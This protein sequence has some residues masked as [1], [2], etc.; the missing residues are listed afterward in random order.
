[1]LLR[2]RGLR[3]LLL[4][5]AG[6]A[7]VLAVGLWALHQQ[8]LN[9]E[10]RHLS[11]LAAAVA[12]QADAT[13]DAADAA[14]RAT[15]D[16]LRAGLLQP[17]SPAAETLLQARITALPHFRALVITDAAGRPVATSTRV[18]MANL[19]L[20]GREVA[21]TLGESAGGEPWVGAP[22][23]TPLDGRLAVTLATDW[24]DA[25]GSFRGTVA[26]LADPEFL[27]R[28]FARL[29]VSAD[30]RMAILRRDLALIADGPG[31]P[32][33]DPLPPELVKSLWQQPT[34]HTQRVTLTRGGERLLAARVLDRHRLLLLVTRDANVALAAWTQQAAVV[35]TFAAS[36]LLAT[37]LLGLRHAQEQVLR[38][39]AEE[40]LAQDQARALRAVQAAQEGAWEWQ[41]NSGHGFLSPRMR[42][43]LSIAP[44]ACAEAG[45]LQPTLHPDDFNALHQV[46]A[47]ARDI[48]FEHEFRVRHEQADW[49]HLRVRVRGMATPDGAGWL[50]GGT[51]V[52]I[53]A[54]V[55]ARQERERL[56]AQLALARRLEALGTLAGG[57]AHDFNNILASV[58][59]YSEVALEKVGAQGSAA[60][61]LQQVLQAG[62]RGRS[63][64]ERVLAF[65]RGAA[66]ATGF[67]PLQSLLGEVL[68]RLRARLPPNVTVHDELLAPIAGV[69]ADAAAVYEAVMNVCSNGVQAMHASGG[70]L[71]LRLQERQVETPHTVFEGRLKTGA[72]VQLVVQDEGP[73]IAPQALPRLFEPFYT[74]KAPGEG[75]GLGM[76][77]VHRVMADLGGAIHVENQAAQGARV[78]LWFPLAHGDASTAPGAALADEDVPPGQGQTVLVVDD[79]PALVRLAEDVLAGLGY[80][81]FGITSSS[82]AWR[83]FE[84][85][86]D[87]FNLLLTDQAMPGLLGT[88][89]ATRCRRL[90]PQLPVLLLSGW[91]GADLAE[92]AAA[93][94]IAQCLT[95]PLRRAE[96]ARAVAQALQPEDD[97]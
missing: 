15:R 11:S 97:R 42:E 14:L 27:D 48:P 43:L 2:A 52:D 84:A 33:V 9:A 58:I 95:K 66:G 7:A 13:L 92:R 18:P 67:V 12:A 22:A 46:L 71:Q 41:P 59:G 45:L 16:E 39:R 6:V 86:P 26:L 89:L 34:G 35:A 90:R 20:I 51:A 93:A 38:Q 70:R 83:H 8:V 40:Q 19:P 63:L 23:V 37:L 91:G 54:E 72:Y 17:G 57:V 65:S 28:D 31:D 36:A 60:P 50:L 4:A 47:A 30:T 81:P 76:A 69:H 5:Q 24:R 80:E 29:G 49:R 85:T 94:G 68:Q 32:G 96:L 55:Q 74:T 1:M 10:L 56:Q 25:S 21:A 3:W 82:E 62:E 88:E 87:R 77:V 78:E 44:Q 75:T 64:V 61:E 53:S 79:E 73:G